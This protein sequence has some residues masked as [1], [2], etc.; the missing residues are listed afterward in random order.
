MPT[1]QIKNGGIQG[2]G[3]I[4]PSK[5]ADTQGGGEGVRS[6]KKYGGDIREED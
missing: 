5:F 6:S 2:G 3:W 1:V 4:P